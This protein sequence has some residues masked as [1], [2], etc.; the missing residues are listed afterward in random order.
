MSAVYLDTCIIIGLI[1]GDKRQRSILKALLPKHQIYSSELVRLETRLL[2]IRQNAPV[3]LTQFDRFFSVCKFI[4]L[5]REVFELATQLRA[6]S[7]LKTPDALHLAAAIQAGCTEFWTNDKQLVKAAGK[8]L[9][10]L[11]WAALGDLA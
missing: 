8:A 5:N 1:E 3:K 4:D 7:H 11:D 9:L 2:P 10:V 6:E